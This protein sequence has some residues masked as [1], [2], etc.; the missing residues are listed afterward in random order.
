MVVFAPYFE[1][2]TGENPATLA[3]QSGAEYLTFNTLSF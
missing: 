2:W 3:Q 1:S